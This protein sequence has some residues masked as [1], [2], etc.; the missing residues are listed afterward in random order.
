MS[1]GVPLHDAL[2]EK[3]A[4]RDLFLRSAR[5]PDRARMAIE[6]YALIGER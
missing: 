5:H 4:L 6:G 2:H 1:F 3:Q